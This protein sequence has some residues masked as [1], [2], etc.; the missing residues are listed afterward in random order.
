[1]KRLDVKEM[2]GPGEDWQ[3]RIQ[4]DKRHVRRR[5]PLLAH[6]ANVKGERVREQT[7]RRM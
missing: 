7:S 6:L 5:C 2:R 1:M 3:L 4:P